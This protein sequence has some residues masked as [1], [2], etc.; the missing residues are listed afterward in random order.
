MCNGALRVWDGTRL[1]GLGQLDPITCGVG[2]IPHGRTAVLT[3]LAGNITIGTDSGM[4]Q[5]Y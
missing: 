2:L 5:T 3:S 4:L 1:V